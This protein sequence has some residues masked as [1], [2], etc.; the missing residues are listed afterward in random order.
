M[1][2][3]KVLS[4]AK[5]Q[6]PVDSRILLVGPDNDDDDTFTVRI[7]IQNNNAEIFSYLWRDFTYLFD[8]NSMMVVGR[9]ICEGNYGYLMN[10]L[11]A[12][13]TTIFLN[14]PY[15]IRKQFVEMIPHHMKGE[16]GVGDLLDFYPYNLLEK[17]VSEEVLL[18]LYNCIKD[19]EVEQLKNLMDARFVLARYVSHLY[20][21]FF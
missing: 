21:D 1:D 18:E 6:K 3:H 14:A 8:E 12:Y 4:A 11:L 13:S 20:F 10:K 15:S 19:N 17:D 7:A 2:E 5:Q 9:F 16:Y